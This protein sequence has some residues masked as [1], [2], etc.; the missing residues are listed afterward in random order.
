MFDLKNQIRS[1]LLNFKP[2][3]SARLPETGGSVLLD[4]NE[5]PFDKIID[6]GGVEAN[7]YPD[8]N[9][10]ALR[11]ALSENVEVPLENIFA[12]SGSDEIIDLILRLFCTPNQDE[13]VIIEPTYGMYKVSAELNGITTRTC[14]LGDD[15]DI[16]IS[17]VDEAVNENTKLLFC[18]SPNNPTGNILPADKLLEYTQD[19]GIIDV[20]MDH[21]RAGNLYFNRKCTGAL[22][23]SEPFGG[24]VSRSSLN[25]ISAGSAHAL[26]NFYSDKTV[27]GF[28]PRSG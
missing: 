5:N 2:Y 16:D 17:R 6:V 14:L 26:T 15:F 27:S 22:V 4:A 10:V 8:P 28:M 7:R 23:G 13:V 21:F 3:T 19:K 20:A 11:T 18:C 9:S 24:L 1:E 25:G 12:G